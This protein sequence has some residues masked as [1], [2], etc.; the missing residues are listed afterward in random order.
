MHNKDYNTRW[1]K[2][3]RFCCVNNKPHTPF[4]NYTYLEVLTWA[5]DTNT[6]CTN[7]S[8]PTN[9]TRIWG[10]RLVGFHAGACELHNLGK[11]VVPRNQ[12]HTQ[13][14]ASVSNVNEDYIREQAKIYGRNYACNLRT[15]NEWIKYLCPQTPNLLSDQTLYSKKLERL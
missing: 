7:L 1:P 15:T 8:K 5:L 4:K 14:S 10:L 11:S 3:E 12:T 2:N 6:V 13:E 9:L